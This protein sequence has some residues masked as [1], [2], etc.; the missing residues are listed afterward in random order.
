MHIELKDLKTGKIH[1]IEEKGATFGRD[2][3][4]SSIAVDDSGVSGAHAKIFLRDG[5]WYIED[6]KSSNGTWVDEH[7]VTS[8]T[9]LNQGSRIKLFNYKL[10][11]VG[12]EAVANDG[13]TAVFNAETAIADPHKKV[14]APPAAEAQDED[15]EPPPEPAKAVKSKTSGDLL[16]GDP[17]SS[18][19]APATQ[20][21]VEAHVEPLV[22]KGD[23]DAFGANVKEATA[24][25]LVAIPKLLFNYKGSVKESIDNQR[26]PAMKPPLLIAWALPPLLLGTMVGQLAALM[27]MLAA[28][29]LAMGALITSLVIGVVVMIVASIIVGFIYH[30]VLKWII[31]L[32]KGTSTDVSRSNYF[33]MS[34]TSAGLATVISG[35]GVL[36]LLV[37]LPFIGVVPVLL[38]LVATLISLYIS[39]Q[40]L[41]F[42]GVVKWLLTVILVLGA[43]LGVLTLWNL[44]N[45]VMGGI[46]SL[47][48]GHTNSAVV[49]SPALTTDNEAA[50]KNAE[51]QAAKAM[52]TA[53]LAA[54]A[55]GVAV[56][57]P[58]AMQVPPQGSTLP[59]PP[60]PPAVG[61]KDLTPPPPFAKAAEVKTP[62]SLVNEA[63]SARGGRS[64]DDYATYLQKREAVEQAIEKNPALL[65]RTEGVLPLYKQLHFEMKKVSEKYA[66]QKGGKDVVTER[67]RDA[68]MYDK[69]V[70]QVDALYRKVG[71][72]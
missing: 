35:I 72:Q 28:G 52:A 24:H 42:F 12:M 66:H 23:S 15:L 47:R 9:A 29:H 39:Y 64:S 43:V 25:Y 57:V 2:K 27:T 20:P 59:P 33:V 4:R 51:E 44:K 61:K 63:P 6:L 1:R 71:G 32:F 16:I 60:P 31:N 69:T 14:E 62:S 30:P 49:A 46:D 11:V 58:S 53:G 21:V 3:A 18:K 38:S 5:Q 13:A 7:R 36:F 48:A 8:S 54:G 40:W 37:P 34:M 45:V 67:M 19:A 10:E 50:I 41:K 68:E 26:F 56:P 55:A 70:D 22:T 17:P 65:A